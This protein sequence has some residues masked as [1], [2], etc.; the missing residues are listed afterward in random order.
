M[1]VRKLSYLAIDRLGELLGLTADALSPIY[2]LRSAILQLKE[3]MPPELKEGLDAQLL[4]EGS[5]TEQAEGLQP[6]DSMKLLLTALYCPKKCY[7][8]QMQEKDGTGDTY[9]LLVDGAWLRIDACR[10]LLTISGPFD[11]TAAELYLR[12]CVETALREPDIQLKIERRE[13]G[14]VHG[15]CDRNGQ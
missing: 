6:A 5:L 8:V 9:L 11:L 12:A 15:G 10:G 2:D 1:Q 13:E 3:A 4:A 14:C 7:R